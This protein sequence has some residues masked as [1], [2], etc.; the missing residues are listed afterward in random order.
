M[1]PY[2]PEQ[3]SFFAHILGFAEEKDIHFE[4]LSST[5]DLIVC[6]DNPAFFGVAAVWPAMPVRC[7]SQMSI[8]KLFQYLRM[9]NY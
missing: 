4:V 9:I 1:I 3:Q 7:S 2:P 5:V 8:F 6:S